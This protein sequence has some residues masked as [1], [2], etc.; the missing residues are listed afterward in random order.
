MTLA[1]LL[2]IGSAALIY[3]SCEYF[4]NGVE[5]VGRK[6]S[7]SQTATGSV[8]AAFGTALPES[9]ITFVAVVFGAGPAQKELGVGA[10]IGGPLA[11]ST[12]AF[13]VVGLTFVLRRGGND[14]PLFSTSSAGRLMNDQKWFMAVFVFKIGLGLIAFAFKP[15]LGMLFLVAYGLYVRNELTATHEDSGESEELE[16][17]KFRPRSEAPSTSWA[18]LQTLVALLVIF[19]SSQLFVHQ[20]EVIGPW[21]GM[22]A[23]LAALLFSPI[24]TEL[25]EILNAVIWVRQGKQQLALANISGAMM[26]QATVPSALG[27]F[28]TPW[29]LQPALVWAAVITVVSIVGLYVM[30]V[31]KTLTGPR[32]SWFS[33]LY[34]VFAGGLFFLHA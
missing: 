24:A 11:L 13:A 33:A 4:V 25:P 34:V 6:F 22:P 21:L 26:I 30:L 31:R 28:F 20:L 5:W 2:L 12:V 10:A 27:L 14:G 18:V 8:L 7:V 16:P 23:Q 32:L 17:L 3:L 15:W 1:F 29:L 9:V 19:F